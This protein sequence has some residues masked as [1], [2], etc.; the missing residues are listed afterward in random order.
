MHQVRLF[1]TALQFFTRLPI[2]AWVGFES[3]WLNQASRYFPLVGLVVATI[4]AGVYAL[5]SWLLPAPVAVLLSTSA[6]IYAT[7]AFHEDGFADMCDGFGGGMTPERVLE[8]MKD[9]RI[10]AYGAIGIVCLLGLKCVTLAQ[11]PSMS[12]IGALF[13]AHPVSRLLAA[14]LI[15]RMDYARAEGKAK[16]LAQTMTSGEFA[17]ACIT[18][19]LAIVAVAASSALS[20]AA[21]G[22][23]VLAGLATTVW[24]ARMFSRRIGGYTGDCLGAVQ[25]VSEVMIYL[26]VL[27]CAGLGSLGH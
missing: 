3:A 23:S 4:A 11:L 13:V 6:G 15:W 8:I 2:P 17:V 16:P 14:S 18:A 21:L 24:L 12:V 22:A 7:G 5:A 1:F 27:A 19:L 9:S 10:G 20:S 25:Q 26:G